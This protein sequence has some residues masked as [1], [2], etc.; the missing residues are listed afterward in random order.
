MI[1]KLPIKAAVHSVLC[2]ERAAS[3]KSR[4]EFGRNWLYVVVPEGKHK[5]IIDN[6]R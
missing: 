3:S 4:F 1:V 5:I 6:I 2:D